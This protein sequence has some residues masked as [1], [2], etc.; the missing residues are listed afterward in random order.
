MLELT[1]LPPSLPKSLAFV[2]M[3][4]VAEGMSQAIQYQW[5]T[6]SGGK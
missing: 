6:P 5:A 4:R 2:E 3:L 1:L